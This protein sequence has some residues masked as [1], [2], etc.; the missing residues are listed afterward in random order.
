MAKQVGIIRLQGTIGGIT[1]MH[2]ADGHIAREKSG[3]SRERILH[4]PEFVR[5]RENMNEFDSIVESTK[6]FRNCVGNLLLLAKDNWL[7]RRMMKFMGI[8]K[9][10]DYLNPRGARNVA[11]AL[12]TPSVVS[13]FKGFEFNSH[14]SVGNILQRPFSLDEVT[15]TITIENLRVSEELVF[16]PSAT[17]VVLTAGWTKVDFER[18]TFA[19][20]CSEEVRIEI[21]FGAQ[22][23]VLAP[24]GV[25]QGDGISLHVLR[26]G[27]VQV[28]GGVDYDL[29]NGRFNC[30][31]VVGVG[32]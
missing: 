27:F 13:M 9:K 18:G 23:V 26:I 5:T 19:L 12:I 4:G 2:T 10:K 6:L 28:V 14:A 16:P 20:S 24:N 11:D 22:T 17:H 32:G 1:F 21:G 25:P 7:N 15:G 31:G 29:K 30:L 3:V 8:I